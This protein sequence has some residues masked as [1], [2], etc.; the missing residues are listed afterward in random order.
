MFFIEELSDVATDYFLIKI[1]EDL[2]DVLSTDFS[3]KFSHAAEEAV[4]EVEKWEDVFI[5]GFVVYEEQ[6]VP[7]T[8]DGLRRTKS[9]VNMPDITKFGRQGCFLLGPFEVVH[10]GGLTGVYSWTTVALDTNCVFLDEGWK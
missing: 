9:Y 4:G 8:P 6:A 2:A 7:G 1:C 10:R 3:D 5:P